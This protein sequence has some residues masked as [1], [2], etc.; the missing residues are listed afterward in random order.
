M[1]RSARHGA[2]SDVRQLDDPQKDVHRKHPWTSAHLPNMVPG[3]ESKRGGQMTER[4]SSPARSTAPELNGSEGA[5]PSDW[6]A[7]LGSGE[8]LGPT[9]EE[10]GGVR[11]LDTDSVVGIEV[12]RGGGSLP[13]ADKRPRTQMPSNGVASSYRHFCLYAGGELVS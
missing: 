5:S 13:K 7:A 1:T 12:R 9:H 2:A 3:A 11:W 6:G 10:R 4:R 8:A